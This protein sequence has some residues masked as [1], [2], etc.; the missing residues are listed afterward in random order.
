MLHCWSLSSEG[1]NY[2]L[3]KRL[4][5]F[6]DEDDQTVPAKRARMGSRGIQ[7]PIDAAAYLARLEP[8][9]SLSTLGNPI[10]LQELVEQT[11]GGITQL[12][13]LDDEVQQ[14][15]CTSHAS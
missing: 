1:V 15:S 14:T 12:E 4:K 11:V 6:W 2:T 5:D 8:L 7:N 13:G 3:V 10:V 9:N